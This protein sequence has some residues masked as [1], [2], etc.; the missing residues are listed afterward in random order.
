MKNAHA[1]NEEMALVAKPRRRGK[2]V[3]KIRPSDPAN[4]SNCNNEENPF[5]AESGD[6]VSDAIA[7]KSEIIN[8]P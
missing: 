5:F 4:L 8:E 2:T 6:V 1:N 3:N 7:Q